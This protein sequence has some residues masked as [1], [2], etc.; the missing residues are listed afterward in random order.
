MKKG[1]NPP[2]P[3]DLK[4]PDPPPKPPTIEP[5]TTLYES[6]IKPMRLRINSLEKQVEWLT[7]RLLAFE[8]K[9]LKK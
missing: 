1:S 7:R 4:R 2:P 9:M 5:E 6:D 8:G 3:D